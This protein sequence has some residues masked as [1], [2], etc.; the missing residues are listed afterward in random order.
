MMNTKFLL[1]VSLFT[2]IF[3]NAQFGPQNIVVTNE[4]INIK[5][6]CTS[7]LDNDGDLD[8]LSASDDDHKIAWYEN[9]GNNDFAYQRVISIS[10][11]QASCVTTG[12][13]D[14]DGL[15][16][17]LCTSLGDDKVSW[18]KNLGGGNFGNRQVIT[19]QAAYARY[20]TAKDLNNDGLLDVISASS[21]D[22]KIAWYKNLGGGTFGPQ[23]VLSTSSDEA[24]QVY[25][26]DLDGDLDN[27]VLSLSIIDEKIAWYE[28]LGG[29][30]FTSEQIITN[31]FNAVSA[32]YF[33]DMDMDGDI[34]IL[35][36]SASD[37]KISWFENFGN[38]SFGVEQ[39][40]MNLPNG[41]MSITSTDIDNDGDND[42]LVSS[43]IDS[44]IILIEKTVTGF[45]VPLVIATSLANVTS[46]HPAD[47][48]GDGDIDIVSASFYCVGLHENTGSN[49]SYVKISSDEARLANSV[50]AV[51][52]DL[53]GDIDILAGSNKKIAWYENDGFLNFEVEHSITNNVI[54]VTHILP[55]DLNS[56]GDFDIVSIGQNA[57]VWFENTGNGSFGSQNLI[58]SNVSGDDAVFVGDLDGDGDI[59]VISTDNIV[60]LLWYE[61]ING[62][63]SV[64]HTI[65]SSGLGALHNEVFLEDLDND[66]DQDIIT[67]RGANFSILWY[68][69]FGNGT[70]S[71]PFTLIYP[72]DQAVEIFATDIEGDGDMDV[73]LASQETGYGLIS[74]VKNLG[75]GLFDSQ[76]TIGAVCCN[77]HGIN[78]ADA[79][80][81]GDSDVFSAST[82]GEFIYWYE[83]IDNVVFNQQL[84][85]NQALVPSD[86]YSADING[87]GDMDILSASAFDGEIAWYENYLYYPE[88]VKGK[89]FLDMNQNDLFDLGD[90]GVP[91]YTILSTPQS[92]FTYSFN[93]GSYYMIFSDTL[94]NY[95]IQP[96]VIPHWSITTDSLLYNITINSSFSAMDSL[97]FGLY[98]TVVINELANQLVGGF[99]RCDNHVNYWLNV[100]NTGTTIPSG[101]LSLKLD[102]SLSFV[103]AS[104]MPDSVVGNNIYWHYDS[105]IYF[106]HKQINVDVLFPDSQSTGDNVQSVFCANV[107]DFNGNEIAVFSDTLD[108]IVLCSYDPNDKIVSPI[109]INSNGEIPMSTIWLDYLIR[110]Q[111]TGNDTAYTIEIKD[112]L[113]A[114]LNWQTLSFVAS[115]DSVQMNVN[116][117]GRVSFLFQNIMLPDS[118][119][120][121]IDSH[122]FIQYRIQLK[123]NLSPG[124]QIRNEALIYFDNNAPIT[125]NSTINTL[126]EIDINGV[127]SILYDVESTPFT[128]FPNPMSEYTTIHFNFELVDDYDF[129][130]HSILGEQLFYFKNPK[131]D[132]HLTKEKIAS[133]IYVATLVNKKTSEKVTKRIVVY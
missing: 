61:N 36:G 11:M 98:P 12:D 114:N 55:C 40:I 27:D 4:T 93:N 68:K 83:N 7:D 59:D 72:C 9:L 51:D 64:Q 92:D 2:S 48:N 88:Q 32:V 58:N 91:Q 82:N 39:L 49:F 96:S 1:F 101:V 97:D 14:N 19:N 109:G 73:L 104:I 41:V 37:N 62:N 127:H 28:N 130:I 53:D 95:Q 111:N 21:N 67:T 20:V 42:V 99:P 115:S 47:V 18:F 24:I 131:S 76:Q 122:G 17:V 89:L 50:N 120:N 116:E 123:P 94:G 121:E 16:D 22:D 10:T 81:D 52:F 57:L 85:T 90:F 69:N 78:A 117:N 71:G 100:Q 34:D 8:V 33:E 74:M 31:I 80:G 84:I 77:I 119:S 102:D 125:T 70:F 13:L 56:D 106:N 126:T 105:L 103:S 128:I 29:D 65:S 66:G 118:S 87:D 113:D 3:S 30:N 45:G 38:G 35:A 43:E 60:G 79:D 107:K 112:Y 132:I 86:V 124:T 44:T 129:L 46:M 25:S 133:G 63:F 110:F 108:Q 26:C 75:G 23:I 5:S 6:V 54:A 15:Q